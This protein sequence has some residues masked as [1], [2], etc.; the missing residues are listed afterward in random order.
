M[1]QIRERLLIGVDKFAAKEIWNTYSRM[2]KYIAATDTKK[3]R[4]SIISFFLNNSRYSIMIRRKR[5][6]VSFVRREIRSDRDRSVSCRAEFFFR[7]QS[8][9]AIKPKKKSNSLWEAPIYETD[10]TCM[11]WM[12][13]TRL[14]KK[15]KGFLKNLMKKKNNKQESM[16]WRQSWDIW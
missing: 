8:K 1:R 9:T 16:I 12:R 15:D 11:G 14:R 13:K 4:K 3:G 2:T 7:I 10:S 6:D 5:K